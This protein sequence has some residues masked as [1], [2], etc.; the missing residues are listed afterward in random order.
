[1]SFV[2]RPFQDQDYEA[3]AGI[4]NAL[5]PDDRYSAEDC[6][7]A[8]ER[9]Q[10]RQRYVVLDP[11]TQE[12][13]GEGLVFSAGTDWM[14]LMVHP[15]RHRQ[16]IGC[17]LFRR[18]EKDF[19]A[20]DATA[21]RA[22]ARDDRPN[23]LDFLRKRGFVELWQNVEL[24][25]RVA[26]VDLEPF[27]PLGERLAGQ[28]ITLTTLREERERN[29]EC[30]RKL[31]DLYNRVYSDIPLPDP[32]TPLPFEDFTR[33][34]EG[35][36]TPADAFTIARHGTCYVGISYVTRKEGFPEQLDQQ[37]TGVAGEYRRLGIATALKVRTLQ[38]AQQHGF[39][40]IIT[41]CQSDNAGMLALNERLGFR[42][43]VSWVTFQKSLPPT[44]KTGDRST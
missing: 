43:G 4:W 1:M 9:R 19:R 36:N 29:P 39:Q 12:V 35:G 25:L 26:E 34:A 41:G 40:T 44:V 2:L 23:A 28:G 32:Y 17:H 10:V 13:V 8:D 7:C 21:V 5:Y 11:A 20:W 30:L 31:H 38:Y 27:M 3:I 6:R 22:S 33:L 37:L 14:W 16:G 42:R 15:S 18:L 24:R